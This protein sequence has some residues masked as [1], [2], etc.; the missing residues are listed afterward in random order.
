MPFASFSA[1]YRAALAF[2][3][4]QIS[5]PAFCP[6]YVK[7][8]S[9]LSPWADFFAVLLC[10]SFS[11]N[12]EKGNPRKR[13]KGFCSKMSERPFGHFCRIGGGRSPPGTLFPENRTN[14]R[15]GGS[16]SQVTGCPKL[17][18]ECVLLKIEE[19]NLLIFE[20]VS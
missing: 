18:S 15:F 19:S 6:Y 10:L 3:V 5:N 12:S 17:D 4:Q 1:Y 13:G 2:F 9:A 20:W 16:K 11:Q 14:P 8:L 7:P